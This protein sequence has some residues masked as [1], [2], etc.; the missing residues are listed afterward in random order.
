MKRY[1]D[2]LNDAL[3]RV[4]E[5]QP[6][7]LR[8]RLAGERPPLVLD[9]REPAEFAQAHIPGA[10]SVPRGVLEQACEWDHDETVPELARHAVGAIVVPGHNAA[11]TVD[12]CLAALCG[13][14]LGDGPAG[15]SLEPRP[16]NLV[17]FSPQV[18]DDYLFW[19]IHDGKPGTSMVAWGGVVTEE[20]VWQAVAFIRKEEVVTKL[21]DDLGPRFGQRPGGYSRI[22]K[23]GPRKGDGADMALIELVG[24]EFKK[25]EKKKKGKEAAKKS[26]K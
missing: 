17:T 25:K 19:R 15:A 13:D 12:A 7:D 10:L 3:T 16:V 24:S 6:W 20:Q 9:I 5:I 26:A 4:R 1:A 2:L 22:V 14:A 23:L 8:D 21:F 11:R 18:G